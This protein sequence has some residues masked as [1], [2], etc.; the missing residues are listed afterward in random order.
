MHLAQGVGVDWP[1]EG[2]LAHKRF[3]KPRW[4]GGFYGLSLFVSRKTCT[5]TETPQSSLVNPG[6]GTRVPKPL[7]WDTDI[8]TSKDHSGGRPAHYDCPRL[9]HQGS[10]LVVMLQSH[11]QPKVL[12]PA[13]HSQVFLAGKGRPGGRLA[14]Y[15]MN[16]LLFQPKRK[17]TVP[18]SHLLFGLIQ[19]GQ[20]DD[21]AKFSSRRI[22]LG[23]CMCLLC[24][25]GK[26]SRGIHTESPNKKL[27]YPNCLRIN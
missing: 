23:N 25:Q 20:K 17:R 12:F 5:R 14:S 13:K 15:A 27:P 8:R 21:L 19:W 3:T 26:N 1:V 9:M 2:G 4:G 16:V 18:P 6:L 11:L 24:T 22:L 7:F 10:S